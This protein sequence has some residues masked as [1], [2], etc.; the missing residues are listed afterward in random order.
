MGEENCLFCRIAAGEIPSDIVL[1]DDEFMAFRD[2]NPTAPQHVL[3][4][5][6]R[7]VASLD[8]LTE[9]DTELAGRFLLFAGRVGRS[10][11]VH[12]PGYRT[13]V[14]VNR[15][16]G[17]EVFHLHLHLLGGRALGWPPG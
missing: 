14:N 11:G 8:T 12:E 3:V 5:P 15:G 4:I 1:E 10:L 2:I 16:G 6:K 13:V 9:E 7:H 17:Q